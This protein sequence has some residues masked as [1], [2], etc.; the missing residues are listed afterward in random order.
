MRL[1]KNKVHEYMGSDYLL[2]ADHMKN[3]YNATLETDVDGVKIRKKGFVEENH[4]VSH[5]ANELESY[6]SS[7][8]LL[9][10]E[11][12][13]RSNGSGDSQLLMD[14]LSPGVLQSPSL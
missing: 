12:D 8:P 4:E 2:Q 14:N 9:A 13:E 3:F 5:F 7:N 11:I 10:Y 1:A 6:A